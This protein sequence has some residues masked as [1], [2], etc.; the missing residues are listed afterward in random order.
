[1]DG[2]HPR[3]HP[4]VA[5][6]A[7][8]PGAL[9]LGAVAVQHR[10]LHFRVAHDPAWGME[11]FYIGW[12]RLCAA[13]SHSF[14]ELRD[15]RIGCAVCRSADLEEPETR[16]RQAGYV[17]PDCGGRDAP[18]VN[19]YRISHASRTH[20]PGL[21]AAALAVGPGRIPA[22]ATQESVARCAIYR[23]SCLGAAYAR[24]RRVAP[25]KAVAGVRTVSIPDS[26]VDRVRIYGLH[27]AAAGS[28]FRYGA[29]EPELLGTSPHRRFRYV[30]RDSPDDHG[31]KMDRRRR[32]IGS[33]TVR[34]LRYCVRVVD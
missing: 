10:L 33:G 15:G 18:V 5:H 25:K 32:R 26:G 13:V 2:A 16:D 8:P 1:M 22:P 34:C 27:G 19:S 23:G 14:T 21:V 12:A 31:P 20:T 17:R 28:E 6:R 11:A 9:L 30:C 7:F 3:G 24:R 4:S 29:V